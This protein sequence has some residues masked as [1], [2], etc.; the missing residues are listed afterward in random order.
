MPWCDHQG[1]SNL[2]SHSLNTSSQLKHLID[3]YE[4]GII[5][6]TILLGFLYLAL[7]GFPL[8]LYSLYS[9]KIHE[10]SFLGFWSSFSA[11]IF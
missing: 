5:L 3:L 4:L 1:L 6:I 11:H 9:A 8:C 2:A 10:D 7:Y